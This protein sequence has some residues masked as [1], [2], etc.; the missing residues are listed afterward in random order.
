MAE[1][2]LEL[3]IPLFALRHNA[4]DY[5]DRTLW[6]AGVTAVTLGY[7]LNAIP[8]REQPALP[9]RPTSERR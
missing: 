3:Q 2:V 4:Y 8:S 9:P 1:L 6:D 7:S 5:V